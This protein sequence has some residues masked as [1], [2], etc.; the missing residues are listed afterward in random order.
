MGIIMRLSSLSLAVAV[1]FIGLSSAQA[2]PIT[3]VTTVAAARTEQARALGFDQADFSADGRNNIMIKNA[4]TLRLEPPDCVRAT[5]TKSAR[6]CAA[7]W[8]RC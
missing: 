6:C 8:P 5:L 1:T 7:R 4:G 2:T 3:N